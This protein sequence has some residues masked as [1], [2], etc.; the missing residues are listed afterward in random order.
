MLTINYYFSVSKLPQIACAWSGRKSI[1]QDKY[2]ANLVLEMP[3]VKAAVPQKSIFE[4]FVKNLPNLAIETQE[5]TY[6]ES[7]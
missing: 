3:C 6:Q 1:V 2:M 7:I 5:R 4:Y